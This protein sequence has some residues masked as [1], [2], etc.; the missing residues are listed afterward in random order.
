MRASYT[1]GMVV[2]LLEAGIDFDWVGGISAGSSN[3]CNFL[4]KDP[5]RARQCFTKFAADPQ[6]GGWGSFARGRGYFHADYVYRRTAAPGQ[7]LPFDWE[8]FRANPTP[9][10]IGA[11]NVSTGRN[12]YWGREDIDSLDALMVRVQ[13][14]SSIPVMMPPVHIDGEI[15]VDGAL[16]PTGG[17]ALDAARR[18]GFDRFVVVLS[19]ER[20]FVKSTHAPRQVWAVARQFR[21]HPAVARAL[22]QRAL[23]YNRTRRQ[24]LELEAAGKAYLFFPDRMPVGTTER[25]V[26]LLEASHEAG[27]AQARREIAAIRNF[28]EA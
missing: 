3:L 7:A 25:R 10:R 22:Q 16:G 14:S 23:N 13:A 19:Q 2:A 6:F 5:W 9:F 1:S 28:I 15:Y 11:F 20:S 17:F 24:L 4:S 12:V 18:D 26:P 8:T 27:L 21:R